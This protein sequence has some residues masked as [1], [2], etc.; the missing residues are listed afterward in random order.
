MTTIRYSTDGTSLLFYNVALS[1]LTDFAFGGPE[2]AA[3]RILAQTAIRFIPGVWR[4]CGWSLCVHPE[5]GTGLPLATDG[6]RCVLYC[7]AH[8]TP[9]VHKSNL[10][11]PVGPWDTEV[12]DWNYAANSPKLRIPPPHLAVAKELDA[13]YARMAAYYNALPTEQDEWP[14]SHQFLVSRETQAGGVEALA[15]QIHREREGKTAKSL[16]QKHAPRFSALDEALALL[17]ASK[18]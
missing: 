18:I 16:R 11:G 4:H 12:E 17:R 15:Q 14:K 5:F 6:T 3:R 8:H 9:V 7:A 1:S 13:E 2:P 10:I